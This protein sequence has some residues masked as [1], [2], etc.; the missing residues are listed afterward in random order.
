MEASAADQRLRTL[1]RHFLFRELG[2]AEL[3]EL[4]RCCRI[5]T[6]APRQTIFLKGMP[7]DSMIAILRGEVRISLTGVD[8]HEITLAV[9]GEGDILGEIAVLDGRE[10][11]AD[12]TALCACEALVVER[13][14]FLAFIESR[15]LIA[16]RLLAALCQKLRRT[17]DQ[18]EELSLLDLAGRL[19]R[20]LAALA[21]IHGHKGARGIRIA[22]S[23]TQRDL[24]AMLGA[25]R[26]AV[27]KQLMQWRRQGVIELARGAIVVL[28]PARLAAIAAD[29]PE[30]RR[31]E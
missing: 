15:P 11:T 21:R 7:G 1:R 12:A 18:V 22:A 9:L 13:S 25:S 26:E 8:G 2:E 29:A 27:N 14:R 20:R 24:A 5:E 6:F 4:L 30:A 17:T 28:D 19:A 23:F 16:Q 3:R 31:G 10:R